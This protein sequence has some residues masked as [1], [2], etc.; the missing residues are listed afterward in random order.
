MYTVHGRQRCTPGVQIV[1]QPLL[2]RSY[3]TPG[4]QSLPGRRSAATAPRTSG[5]DGGRGWTSGFGRGAGT[6]EADRD[7]GRGL[8]SVGSKLRDPPRRNPEPG[9]PDVDRG[10]D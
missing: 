2:A 3:R 10:D 6:T 4:V 8:A 5:G 1:D 7:R 9:S